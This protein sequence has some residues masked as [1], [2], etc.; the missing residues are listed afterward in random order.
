M[1][2]SQ[3]K[4]IYKLNKLADKYG[5]YWENGVSVDLNLSQFHNDSILTVYISPKSPK[6]H[7]SRMTISGF[8]GK[9]GGLK[10]NYYINNANGETKMTK[11]ENMTKIASQ[12]TVADLKEQGIKMM[13]SVESHSADVLNA[14]LNA[15]ESKISEE[16]FIAFC[17]AM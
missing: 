11:L 10:Y 16:E 9:N 13:N 2:K 3:M 15:L 12:M 17:D 14:L 1:T 7:E 6:W 8:I 5:K 4:K